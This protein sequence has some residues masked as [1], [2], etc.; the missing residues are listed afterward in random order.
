ML[1]F[2]LAAVILVCSIHSSNAADNS[3]LATDVAIGTIKI[4]YLLSESKPPYRAGAI[5]LAIEQAQSDG[6]LQG[7]NIR[8]VSSFS[9]NVPGIEEKNGSYSL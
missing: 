8:Y 9:S 6:L 5:N 2:W 7:F 1:Q 3:S 4:G